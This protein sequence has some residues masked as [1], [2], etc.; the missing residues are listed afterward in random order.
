MNGIF[1]WIQTNMLFLLLNPQCCG[2]RLTQTVMYT[3]YSNVVHIREYP[4]LWHR[5]WKDIW[6]LSCRILTTTILDE[7]KT[8]FILPN[9]GVASQVRSNP[10]ALHHSTRCGE[11][12]NLNYSHHES[13]VR[14]VRRHNIS[15]LQWCPAPL[16]RHY[17]YPGIK[18]LKCNGL[19]LWQATV[20]VTVGP[21]RTVFH[22]I[23]GRRS[24]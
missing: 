4:H 14:Q 22:C 24:R 12:S 16:G 11:V 18:C 8:M 2:L 23:P 1:Y 7:P 3:K 10:R 15:I 9:C 20:V 5:I 21:H 19:I 13:N 17:K 6:I